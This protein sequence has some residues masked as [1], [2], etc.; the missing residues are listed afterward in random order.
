MAADPVHQRHGPRS[1]LALAFDAEDQAA[2]GTLQ[3][4]PPSGGR[5]ADAD[6]LHL[7]MLFLGSQPEEVLASLVRE[8]PA[9]PASPLRLS[10]GSVELLQGR[11]GRRFSRASVEL[12][13]QLETLRNAVVAWAARFASLPAEGFSFAPHVTLATLPPAAA[14]V[15]EAASTDALAGTGLPERRILT[16]PLVLTPWAVGLF[17]SAFRGDVPVYQALGFHPFPALDEGSAS[18]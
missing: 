7:T 15:E 13:P 2:L 12:S 10:V 16:P 11:S 4:E 14:Q 1:F 9:L 8:L 18:T 5:N 17:T 6:Q 3:G